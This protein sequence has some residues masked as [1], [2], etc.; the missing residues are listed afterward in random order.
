MGFKS[1]ALVASTLVLST[2][3]NAVTYNFYQSGYAE[4]AFVSGTF[5]G[6]DLDF[7][8]QLSSFN[9]EVTDFTMSFSGNSLV[10]TF[11][12]GFL[13][14]DGV[15]YDLNGGPLGDGTSLEVEGIAAQ[16]SP[17][18]LGYVVG[19]GPFGVLCGIGADC[20]TV[21]NSTFGD[22]STELV[23]V[24]SVPVPAAVWLFGSGLLGLVGVARRKKA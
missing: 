18:A 4:G 10:P 19:L 16:N 5:T 12:L 7:N 17:L 6:D 9:N 2:S 24:S 15:V 22:Y 20:A 8:G 21:A 13:D 3:V 14:L 1:I 23:S 11:S